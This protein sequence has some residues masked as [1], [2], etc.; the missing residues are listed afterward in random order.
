MGPKKGIGGQTIIFFYVETN[1][2]I[3][4]EFSELEFSEQKFL[5]TLPFLLDE[6]LLEK[7][8]FRPFLMSFLVRKVF[9][10]YLRRNKS[11]S[12]ALNGDEFFI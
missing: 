3:W 8:N 9:F 11:K 4:L 12:L 5:V 2:I 1:I 7:K 6:F 10:F